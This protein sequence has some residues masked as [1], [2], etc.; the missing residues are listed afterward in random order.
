MRA[1]ATL[2]CWILLLTAAGD[3]ATAAPVVNAV[4]GIASQGDTLRV[5]GSGFGFKS[6]AAP[7][8]YDNFEGGQ[9]GSTLP[10]QSDGGWTTSSNNATLPSYSRA[11]QRLPGETCVLQDYS[12][13]YRQEIGLRGIDADTLYMTGWCYRDDYAGTAMLSSNQKLWG[14]FSYAGELPQCR[15]DTYWSTSSGHLYVVD[16]Q[17]NDTLHDW[18]LGASPYLD[19]WFRLERYMAMGSPGGDDG[20]TWIGADLQRIASVEGTIYT[21][22]NPYDS[23]YIGHFYRKSDGGSLRVYWSEMY[24]D[25]TLARIEL[26]NAPQWDA[27]TRREIQIPVAWSDTQAEFI[28]NLGTFGQG[29]T[30][31]LYVVDRAG[32]HPTAG[33]PV[34]VGQT[35]DPGPPGPPSQ[36]KA[37]GG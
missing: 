18:G 14:N 16:G 12:T 7:L 2:L 25:N 15:G 20:R 4:E 5:V 32:D 9:E 35:N 21:T 1:A 24:V 23:W 22:G 26:G 33:V 11:R 31:Y 13:A 34:T 8:R 27:C 17:G 28:C 36:P 37:M 29:E 3:A 30:A 6:P 10:A 19:R